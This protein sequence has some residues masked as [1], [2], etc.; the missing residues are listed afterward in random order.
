MVVVLHESPCADLALEGRIKASG[1]DVVR[2]ESIG[3]LHAV[4]SRT[5]PEAVICPRGM[6]S[7]RRIHP[8]THLQ[9]AESLISVISWNADQDG[10]IQVRA[11][12][13]WDAIHDKEMR[14]KRAETIARLT[15]AI[16]S[17]QAKDRAQDVNARS[18]RPYGENSKIS[19]LIDTLAN[20]GTVGMT[21]SQLS[22]LLWGTE[23]ESRE[24]LVRSYISRARDLL[25][26]SSPGLMIYRKGRRYILERIAD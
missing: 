2:A 7:E 11:N 8:H 4:M 17:V 20:A 6:L 13:F 16:Q 5:M 1:F 12:T 22:L 19:L 23:D 10:R 15:E 25:P 21:V 24:P 3:D 26:V 9:E 18:Q 14:S